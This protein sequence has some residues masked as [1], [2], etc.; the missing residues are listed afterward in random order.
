[1]SERCGGARCEGR[2]ET[3]FE[4]GQTRFQF[5]TVAN[6]DADER[7]SVNAPQPARES[8]P[9]DTAAPWRAMDPE[10]GGLVV[11]CADCWP[12]VEAQVRGRSGVTVRVLG[13]RPPW[14]QC[15]VCDPERV[16]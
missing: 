3:P 9:R 12:E 10:V 13:A 2:H 16:C 15:A 14:A 7:L 11:V 5:D 4:C 1:M 8:E 6:V